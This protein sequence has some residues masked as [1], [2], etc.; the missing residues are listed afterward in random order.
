M[1]GPLLLVAALGLFAVL[2]ANSKLLSGQ[3]PPA[4]VV[5]SRYAVL[6]VLL[7]LARLLRPGL[8]GPLA[9]RHPLLQMLRS[10]AMVGS[11]F[12]FY[13]AM[14]R[15][16]LAEGYLVYFTAPFMVLGLFHLVLRERAPLAAWACC[17]LGFS[18]VLAA[19]WPGL[20]A[21]GELAAYGWALFGTFCYATVM[22]INRAL[23]HE[24]GQARL[25][26]WSSTPG[27]LAVAPFA[28]ADWLAPGPWDALALA[29]NGVLAGGATLCLAAAFRH[30]SAARLA[31]V[32][33]S[34]LI[35]AVLFDVMVWGHWPPAATWIGAV[36]VVAA[37]LLAQ[38]AAKGAR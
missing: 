31:P 10:A 25:I 17:A 22:T 24:P 9:T 12:S 30:A 11:A 20:R 28:L 29:A 34:A 21:G 13:L 36:I 23:R 26:L 38:R 37:G 3:Y 19:L 4:Q 15:L 6:L 2:D 14:R 27:L 35:W 1:R 7:A 33:F 5:A 16:P 18:G 32:E 8:G